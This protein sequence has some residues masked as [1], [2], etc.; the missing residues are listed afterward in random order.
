GVIIG[1]D[2][3]LTA[4]HVVDSNGVFQIR[5]SDN[6]LYSVKTVLLDVDDDLAVVVIEGVF[7]QP[8]A[9]LCPAPLVVGDAVRAVGTPSEV[10]LMNCILPGHVVKV[11]FDVEELGEYGLDVTDCHGMSG[12]SGGPLIDSRGRVRAIVV[13]SNRMLLSA[14]PVGR[15][16]EGL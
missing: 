5:T 1:P 12:C 16:D 6:A 14:V 9:V 7:S 4:K 11:D 3:V 10:R 2:R 15:L 8:P 13:V